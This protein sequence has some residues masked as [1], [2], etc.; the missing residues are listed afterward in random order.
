MNKITKI[1]SIAFIAWLTSCAINSH[2]EPAIEKVIVNNTMYRVEWKSIV[3]GL[4]TVVDTVF[5]PGDSIV[6]Y[7]GPGSNC[8]GKIF[9]CH[10]LHS[11][12]LRFK[13][14]PD[15]CLSFV[16]E[17]FHGDIIGET[18]DLRSLAVFET[19][20]ASDTLFRDKA[21]ITQ[22]HFD[23]AVVCEDES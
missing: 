4:R 22:A 1:L 12:Y 5:N 8:P 13:S 10:K 21:E 17:I 19:V 7:V 14:N 20:Y 6:D 11:L 9:P 18:L 23:V 2:G 15:R 16:G 3:G